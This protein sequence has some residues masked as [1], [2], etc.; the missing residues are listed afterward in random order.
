MNISENTLAILKNFATINESISVKPGNMI[1]TISQQK[2]IFASYQAEE[3]F[4]TPFAI[5]RLMEF[6]GCLSLFENP[7]LEFFKDYVTISGKNS[8]KSNYFYCNEAMFVTPPDKDLKLPKDSV[9]FNLPEAHFKKILQATSVLS[10]PE[11]RFCSKDGKIV[12]ECINSEN[13]SSNNLSF[14]LGE[15][16]KDFSAVIK[17]ENLK[18]IPKSYDVTVTKSMVNFTGLEGKLQYFVAVKVDK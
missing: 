7:D 8:M 18:I 5:Y 16:D 10:L 17:T 12:V 11:V 14:E 9:K 6:I 1:R 15:S 3:D 2:T 13:K 4:E